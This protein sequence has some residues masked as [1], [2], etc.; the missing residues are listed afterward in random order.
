MWATKW[1]SLETKPGALR[2]EVCCPPVGSWADLWPHCCPTA[3]KTLHLQ[4]RTTGQYRWSSE[5][6]GHPLTR[7]LLMAAQVMSNNYW[8]FFRLAMAAIA[9]CLNFT[10]SSL[11]NSNRRSNMLLWWGLSSWMFSS[12]WGVGQ[13]DW[14]SLYF[15]N[16]IYHV[17]QHTTS[18]LQLADDGDA[19][20]RHLRLPRPSWQ[21]HQPRN[22]VRRY[23]RWHA[24]FKWVWW[25]KNGGLGRSGGI[26]PTPKRRWVEF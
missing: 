1:W 16:L 6:Q 14:W 17:T 7:E 10:S 24:K 4:G 20:V 23:F 22:L 5:V 21:L 13:C 9:R 26:S 11:R 19:V 3:L 2:A 25:R 18:H 8:P 15:K 12:G